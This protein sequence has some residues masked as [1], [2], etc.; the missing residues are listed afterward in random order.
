MA[1][2]FTLTINRPYGSIRIEDNSLPKLVTDLVTISKDVE[3]VDR[4]IQNSQATPDSGSYEHI[5]GSSLSSPV[6]LPHERRQV[7]DKELIGILLFVRDPRPCAPSELH[8]AMKQNEHPSKG[9]SA[10]LSEMKSE[11]LIF[12]DGAGYRLS[13]TGKNWMKAVSRKLL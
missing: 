9:C 10:R 13:Y 11:G 7:S 1:I 12:K 2:S 4:V 8:R 6:L 3:R 5:L